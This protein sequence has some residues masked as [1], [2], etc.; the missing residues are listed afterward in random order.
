MDYKTE[1]KNRENG[2]RPVPDGLIEIVPSAGEDAADTEETGAGKNAADALPG[3]EERQVKAGGASKSRKQPE[4]QGADQKNGVLSEIISWLQI[5]VS[6]VILAF[7]LNTFIIAN[8]TVPTG[9]MIPTIN[10]GNRVIGSRLSYT[11]GEPERGDIAIFKF[12]WICP[13]CKAM[14]E[15]PAPDICPRCGKTLSHPKTLYYVKRVIGVPGDVIDI[16]PEGSVKAGEL[17]EINVS[18]PNGPD[19]NAELTTA[20]VYLNG[21]KLDEPYLNE[22]MLYSDETPTHFEVPE[23]SYFL[24]GDN[25]NNSMDARYWNNH[26]I[27]K[28]KMVAKVLFRYFPSPSLLK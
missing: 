27:E 23:G 21:E 15:N 26:Y 28:D 6:A 5:I 13:N 8:S 19:D 24:M 16:K 3:E 12:G 7:V 17:S 22:P 10:E 1:E 20:A 9:S 11:F 25:R 14:G 2:A 18:M 4:R